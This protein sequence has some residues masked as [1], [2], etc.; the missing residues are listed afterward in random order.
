MVKFPE[1]EARL[2]R[3]VFVCRKCKTKLRAP[4]LKV[5]AGRISCRNCG[6]SALRAVRK[7]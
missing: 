1:A 2:Y 3:N 4:S 7:K 5:S 6:K